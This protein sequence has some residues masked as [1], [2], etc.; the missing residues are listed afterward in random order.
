L[1]VLLSGLRDTPASRYELPPV[2]ESA[3]GRADAVLRDAGLQ[4]GAYVV[5]H[6]G[7]GSPLREWPAAKWRQLAGELTADGHWLAYTGSGDEQA[8]RVAEVTRD[9]PRCVDLC[10]RL[11]WQEFVRVVARAQLLVGVETVAAHVAAACGTPS[12]AIWTGIGRLGHWRP[13]GGECTAL[14]SPVPCAP[15]FRSRG[16]EAMS[17]VRDVPVARVLEA[18]RSHLRRANADLEAPR[19]RHAAGALP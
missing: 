3:R 9:L 4:P 10:N 18:V 1:R 15:C 6:M 2:P 13:L 5:V 14:I 11:D 7:S 12:V 19:A 16:C 17:C 8:R